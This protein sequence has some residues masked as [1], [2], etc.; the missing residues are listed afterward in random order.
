MTGPDQPA[1]RSVRV[2]GGGT[3]SAPADTARLRLRAT[4]HRPSAAEV[5]Q[6]VDTCVDD[7][8]AALAD[9]G[10]QAASA[11][12]FLVSEEPW[13]T[14]PTSGFDVSTPGGF[15]AGHGLHTTVPLHGGTGVAAVLASVLAA[16]GDALALDGVD[17]GVADPE[18]LRSS[19]RTAAWADATRTAEHN[20][21]AAGCRLGR[22]LEVTEGAGGRADG[23]YDGGYVGGYDGGGPA[24]TAAAVEPSAIDVTVHVTVRWELD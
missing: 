7:A 8:R 6:A 13:R 23:G 10:L 3:A 5:M 19:A 12:L 24:V 20:A 14:D 21:A 1:G 17:F 2:T 22:V 11:D 4:A 9:L 16:G 15:R 18:P